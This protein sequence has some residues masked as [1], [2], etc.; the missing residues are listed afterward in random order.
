MK[1]LLF[2]IALTLILSCEKEKDEPRCWTCTTT[3][4]T[5]YSIQ[6]EGYPRTNKYAEAVCEFTEEGI[7]KYEAANSDTT[8]SV[9]PSY[10]WTQEKVVK[11]E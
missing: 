4:Y 2:L 5:Y 10:V 1:K 7:R 9:K 11:C 8:I 3:Y 6:M